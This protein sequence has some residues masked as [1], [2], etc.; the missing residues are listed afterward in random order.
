M[1]SSN[2][3]KASTAGSNYRGARP[4]GA[5]DDMSKL[6][7]NSDSITNQVTVL[8]SGVI[9]VCYCPFALT[10]MGVLLNVVAAS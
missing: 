6:V 5:A 1:E 9:A 7:F 2:G 3:L 8:K 10:Q 4:T